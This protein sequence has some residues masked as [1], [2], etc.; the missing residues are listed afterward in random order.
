VGITWNA[1]GGIR[2]TRAN[3]SMLDVPIQWQ[4]DSSSGGGN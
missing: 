3:G 2:F 4:A 1:Y